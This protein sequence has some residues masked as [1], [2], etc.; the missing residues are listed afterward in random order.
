MLV[1]VSWGKNVKSLALRKCP[2]INSTAVI[3]T[4]I[5][6]LVIVS[7]ERCSPGKRP[8]DDLRQEPGVSRG[9]S[10]T[11][12]CLSPRSVPRVA[13]RLPCVEPRGA[14]G[15]AQTAQTV[16]GRARR[17]RKAA[18]LGGIRRRGGQLGGFPPVNESDCAAAAARPRLRPRPR[19]P[20]PRAETPA[21]PR[22]SQ[23]RP[24]PPGR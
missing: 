11:T 7:L 9:A 1:T 15:A 6:L 16:P 3:I 8:A 5:L 21:C 20:S 10:Q 12:T 18:V 14:G 4:A 23:L 22:A 13:A 2:V 19:A 24:P 17:G